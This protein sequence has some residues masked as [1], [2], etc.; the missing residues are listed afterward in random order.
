M[1]FAYLFFVRRFIALPHGV[2]PLSM[3]IVGRLGAAFQGDAHA[4]GVLCSANVPRFAPPL[5]RYAEHT[6][7]ASDIRA[8]VDQRCTSSAS[9]CE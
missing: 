1:E 5:F 2:Y 4:D 7:G 3:W 9:M 6:A 8:V